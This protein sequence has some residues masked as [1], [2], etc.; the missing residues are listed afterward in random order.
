MPAAPAA[1]AA[2]SATA[3]P[4]ATP[5]DIKR[6]SAQLRGTLGQELAEDTD[7]FTAE[8]QAVLK[9]HGI[10]QQDDR[11]QRRARTQARQDLAYACMVRTSVPGGVLTA[12]QWLVLD[13]LADQVG[14]GALRITTRQGI[15]YHG[16]VKADLRKLVGT[17]NR[18]LVTTLAACGDVVRNVSC[19]SAPHDDRRQDALLAH[20]RHLA[21]R[22]RPR[23]GAYYEVWLDGEH[24][25]TASPP[26]EPEEPLYGEVYLPRKFKIGLAWPGDNCIDVYSHDVGLV[27]VDRGGVEGFV[28]LVGGGLG[29]SHAREDDTYPR[30]ATPLAWCTASELAEVVEAVITVQRDHGNRADRQRARLKYLLDERGEA[31]FRGEVEARLGRSLPD[32]PELPAWTAAD[33]HLGWHRQEDG[34]WFLGVHVDSGRVRDDG[35][36]HQRTALR[37]IAERFAQEIRLTARQD[38][39]LC[40]IE[41]RDRREIEAILRRHGVPLAEELPPVRRLAVACPAL[42]TCGQALG[43]AERVLPRISATIEAELGALGLDGTEVRVHITGCPNGCARPYT[44]EIGI[45]GR[46]KTAY[47]I[48]VGGAATGER[49]ARRF[50]TSVK[51]ADLGDRLRP[52]LEQYR[53]E[54]VAGEGVGDFADRLGLG[55]PARTE[56]ITCPS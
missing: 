2:E 18:H 54:R 1:R 47:D 33:E 38:V 23:T 13:A 45:V 31:W 6:A 53:D 36:Q 56:V 41:G 10:Y 26:G 20:A 11:D 24:A 55:E 37:E 28:L 19:C 32:A 17:L 15:Q 22:F 12:D 27:P 42:P 35:D 9:F 44:A 16:V 25:V 52:L 8:N 50:A 43:E 7:R 40:G 5:E 29:M 48:Y 51:L 14:G 46:T 21:A 49:L 4:P 39:L 3:A 30:L 34:R